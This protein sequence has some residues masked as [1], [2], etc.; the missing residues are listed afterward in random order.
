LGSLEEVAGENEESAT[1]DRERVALLTSACMAAQ[2]ERAAL[3][4]ILETKVGVSSF[5]VVLIL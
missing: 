4:Q 3:H 1:R 5:E 2:K